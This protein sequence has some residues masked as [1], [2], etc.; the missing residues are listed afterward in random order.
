[1][2]RLVSLSIVA[3][4]ML[5]AAERSGGEGT[6]SSAPGNA[7][8]TG[9]ALT[10][11]DRVSATGT[12]ATSFEIPVPPAPGAPQVA[13]SY[14]SG[15]GG[16]LAG[17]GWDLS[18]GWPM[19]ITRDIRF[20]TPQWK[21][22]ANWVWG[23][24]PVVRENPT[25]PDCANDGWCRYRTA[26]DSLAEV[27]IGLTR[28]T[29]PT[30]EIGATVR[31]PSGT[32]LSYEP[33]LYDGT[34]YPSP[35]AGAATSVLAFRLA[36]AT[37]R[38]GHLTC[39]RYEA[40][41]DPQ[42]GSVAMLSEIAYAS[43]GH[44]TNCSQVFASGT[45]HHVDFGYDPL[46]FSQGSGFFS[47]WT[48]RY[49]A[50]MSFTQLLRTIEVHPAGVQQAQ[51][52]FKLVY[53]GATSETHRPLLSRIEQLV[54]TASGVLTPRTVRAFRYGERSAQFGT[55]NVIEFDSAVSVPDS[56]AGSVSR[57]MKRINPFDNPG[58]LVTNPA[59]LFQAGQ[60]VG[61]DV[62]PPTHATTEQWSFTDVSGD[63]LP[64][65]LWGKET[66]FASTPWSTFEGLAPV[67]RASRPPQQQIL[68]NEGVSA[69]SKLGTSSVTLDTGAPALSSRYPQDLPVSQTSSYSA[70][71]WGDGRG[72]T[73]TGIPVSVSAAEVANRAASCPPAPNQDTRLWPLLPD[74]TTTYAP[75]GSVGEA[76][77]NFGVPHLQPNSY[78][79]N[80]VLGILEGIYSGFHPSYAVSSNVS[81]WVDLDGDGVLEFVATPSGIER[82][83]IDATT[84]RSARAE[85]QADRS[86]R[87][88]SGL[89]VAD[90]R[91]SLSEPG[92]HRVA[93]RFIP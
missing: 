19:S 5:A 63:G 76:V 88:L 53:G 28:T 60:D 59:A 80:P 8:P 61:P 7:S 91:G 49:G 30:R 73:R 78:F 13:L 81:G 85:L 44:P 27:E 47:T 32:T 46:A 29:A 79:G 86:A 74:G 4:L 39:L 55:P 70:W 66:G 14:D 56:L 15:A 64:D 54:A 25:D 31:F 38:N 77:T 6:V 12:Y 18:I 71:F 62:A 22:D 21:L 24:H 84:R 48:M 10:D 89:N 75:A 72:E 34:H 3:V 20:G 11:N 92:R 87:D 23:S 83:H 67:S 1:L 82:F 16:A 42:R 45:R 65:L 50:A 40:A 2:R 41:N 51:D 33:I 26:P 69:G 90:G 52:T 35:P 17:V 93:G 43:A 57:P 37:D 36:S 9:A 58:G 68:V